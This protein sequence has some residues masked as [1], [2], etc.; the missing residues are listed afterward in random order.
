MLAALLDLVLPR[1]CAGCRA[2]G[3]PL[4]LPCRA[5]LDAS[6]LGRV[7]PD[8]CPMGLPAVLAHA[9]YDGVVRALLIAHKER[10][11]LGL[12]RPLGQ[13]LGAV[14]VSFGPGPFVVCAVPS[15]RSAVRARGYDHAQRL[16]R[17]AVGELRRRGVA[18]GAAKLLEPVRAVAD[19]SGLTTGQRAQNL[20]GALRASGAP[21][22]RVVLVDDVVTTGATLV[23]A[24]RAL[25]AGGHEVL[26]AAVL[27]ATMRRLPPGPSHRLSPRRGSPL[28]PA[29][30]EG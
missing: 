22:A 16:A 11:A 14:A 12:T 15:S 10:A 21:P 2:P 20:R 27:G 29:R 23:E 6:P 19:Q 3:Q 8:P 25:R 26:G 30:V 17:A 13:A 24:T 7:R 4:C 18:A 1:A 28:H 9:S 5:A